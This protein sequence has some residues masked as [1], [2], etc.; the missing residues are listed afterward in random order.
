MSVMLQK[1]T[2]EV[3]KHMYE[4]SLI[5]EFSTGGVKYTSFSK[6]DYLHL[7]VGGVLTP[8]DTLDRVRLTIR[9]AFDISEGVLDKLP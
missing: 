2:V 9:G 6:A 3:L 1:E 5:E 7:R 4:T 8:P